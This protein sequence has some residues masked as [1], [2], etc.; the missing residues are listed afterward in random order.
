A[1]GCA[2]GGSGG[3]APRASGGET[4]KNDPTTTEKDLTVVPLADCWGNRAGRP[5]RSR[6]G[7]CPRRQRLLA[8]VI[9]GMSCPKRL[10]G[11]RLIRQGTS[12]L[13]P[14]QRHPPALHLSLSVAESKRSGR[15]DSHRCGINAR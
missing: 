8:V 10:M 15:I 11:R 14:A 1:R 5:R 2:G 3:G 4:R 12:S 13:L 6:T 7:N 9:H